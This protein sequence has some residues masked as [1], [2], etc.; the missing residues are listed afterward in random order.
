MNLQEKLVGSNKVELTRNPC[1]FTKQKQEKTLTSVFSLAQNPRLINKFQTKKQP[2]PTHPTCK[3]VKK[4][5]KTL[6]KT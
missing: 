3:S 4:S 2:I 6:V 5:S 1:K